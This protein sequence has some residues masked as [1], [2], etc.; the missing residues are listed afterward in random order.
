MGSL[1]R[2]GQTDMQSRMAQRPRAIYR[3]RLND[4]LERISQRFYGTAD[5]WRLIYDANNLNTI[6]VLPN[7]ELIIP[8]RAA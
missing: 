6:Y 7:T 5:A 2:A 4:S 8:E 3:T 1:A